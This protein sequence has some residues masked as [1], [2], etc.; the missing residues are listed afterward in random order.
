MTARYLQDCVACVLCFVLVGLDIWK[1]LAPGL[2]LYDMHTI[3]DQRKLLLC[4]L[5]NGD[6]NK[7]AS[8]AEEHIASV[9]FWP[10]Q[11]PTVLAKNVT[12]ETMLLG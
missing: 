7:S 11:N 6:P 2:F 10:S 3:L 5:A 8:F 4:A 1:K 12:W 9:I